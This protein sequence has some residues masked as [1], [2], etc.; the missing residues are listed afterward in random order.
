MLVGKYVPIILGGVLARVGANASRTAASNVVAATILEQ[1]GALAAASLV[2]AA[3]IV[4]TF[5]PLLGIAILVLALL[6]AAIVPFVTA[7]TLQL[8]LW[9]RS[10]VRRQSGFDIA[11][12][13]RNSARI[14]WLMQIAQWVVLSIFVALVLHAL[15]P[16]AD[17]CAFSICAARTAL[18]SWS[19]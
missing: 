1:C 9:L 10:R 12:L 18:P 8:M 11:L 13:D 6:A 16:G 19:A 17:L 5:V 2:G 7:P 4:Y 15:Q 3:C 14:A